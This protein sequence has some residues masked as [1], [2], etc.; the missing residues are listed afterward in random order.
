MFCA[1]AASGTFDERAP[2]TMGAGLAAAVLVDAA[3]VRLVPVPAAMEVLGERDRWF[4]ALTF[5]RLTRSRN[6]T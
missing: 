3:V 6:V 5:P 1:F 4:P 2:R